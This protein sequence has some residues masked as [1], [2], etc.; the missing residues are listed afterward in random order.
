MSKIKLDLDYA[1][2]RKRIELAKADMKPSLWAKNLTISKNIVTNIHGETKQ[3]PSIE[4]IVLV[5]NFTGKPIEWY[6]YGKPAQQND[7]SLVQ[8]E[9][10]KQYGND[11]PGFLCGCKKE[12]IEAC[13]DVK[14]IFESDNDEV[15]DALSA[16]IKVFKH[17][18]KQ[19]KRI[20]KLENKIKYMVKD[21]SKTQDGDS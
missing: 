4:Y 20:T 14:E 10:T 2:I 9:P 7:I 15:A 21:T 12:T 19:D 1:E 11:T 8:D 6:L 3:N 5:A 17:T 18:V 16:N 13:K